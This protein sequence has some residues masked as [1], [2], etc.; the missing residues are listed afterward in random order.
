M[1][2]RHACNIVIYINVHKL[3]LHLLNLEQIISP[4]VAHFIS[5][6]YLLWPIEPEISGDSGLEKKHKKLASWRQWFF[7]P[8][9]Q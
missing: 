6:R 1:T 9:Q 3:H 7:P 4:H 5:P 2:L 8:I